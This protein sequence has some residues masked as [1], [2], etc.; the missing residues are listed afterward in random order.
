MFPDFGLQFDQRSF[1]LVIRQQ[2]LAARKGIT[3]TSRQNLGVHVNR[4]FLHVLA[5]IQADGVARLL[6]LGG[7]SERP[8]RS[9]SLLLRGCGRGRLLRWRRRC[10]LLWRSSG[11]RLL[12][13][14]N[15]HRVNPEGEQS[16]RDRDLFSHCV[17]L[18]SLA[19][20]AKSSVRFLATIGYRSLCARPRCALLNTVRRQRREASAECPG[21]LD[22]SH[23]AA[24]LL[25]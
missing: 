1:R 7:E 14:D 25:S 11:W 23:R 24:L 15:T 19:C 8:L 4:I 2:R 21:R 5:D 9:C 18:S 12:R 16:C 6:L 10:G 13:G 20:S 22:E 17:I 3:N